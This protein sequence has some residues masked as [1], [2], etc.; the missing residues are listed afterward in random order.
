MPLDY[1]LDV[2]SAAGLSNTEHAAGFR[3]VCRET[4][5]RVMAGRPT[6]F[7]SLVGVIVLTL[8]VFGT[9][10]CTAAEPARIGI[11]STLSGPEAVLGADVRDGARLAVD[12]AIAA[13]ANVET[14]VYDDRGTVAG[15]RDAERHAMADRAIVVVG[16]V[17]TALSAEVGPQYARDGLCS[18][19]PT[20]HGDQ[21]TRNATTFRPL[22]SASEMGAALANYLRYALGGTRAVVIYRENAFGR[23]LA[24]GFERVANHGGLAVDARGYT[25]LAQAA[26]LA[27]DVARDPNHPAVII[28][29][30]DVDAVPIVTTLRRA[31]A[32]NLILGPSAIADDTF[33]RNFAG[34]PEERGGRGFFTNGIYAASP[35]ILD[36][37]NAAT[38]SFAQRFRARFLRDPS[39]YATQGYESALLAIAAA[40]TAAGD[41]KATTDRA[42]RDAVRAYLI[43]LDGPAHALPGLLGPLWFT[44]ARGRVEDVRIGRFYFDHLE[45]APLQ[46]VPVTNFDAADVG[47][48]AVVDLGDGRFARRQRVVYSGIF[49]NEIPRL[50]IAQSLFTADFY[51]WIRYA[52]GRWPGAADPADIE[53][54]DLQ[55]GVFDATK[56]SAS[57]DLP[58]GTS[59]RLWHV[60][61]DFKNAFD[62]HRFP[63]DTQTLTI[64]YF[65]ATA[66]SDRIMYAD[67]L[68]ASAQTNTGSTAHSDRTAPDALAELTQWTPLRVSRG[69]AVLVTPSALGDPR[70]VGLERQREL[71]GFQSTV[72]LRR[73][74]SA[75][76]LKNLLPL[77][78]MT[79]IMFAALYFPATLVKEKVTVAITAALSGAV[80]L[81]SINGQLGGVGYTIL[82]EYVFFVFFGLCLLSIV[83][84][85][86]AERLRASNHGTAAARADQIT[87]GV[88]AGTVIV[89]CGLAWM[90]AR[91]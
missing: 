83:S 68:R 67:D 53:F 51:L 65:N 18:I 46:L 71:S 77:G 63:L 8:F 4:P 37:A 76:L 85:L 36:S 17:L 56:P 74:T 1:A 7:A 48:G 27:H 69:R 14:A 78:L 10:V 23:P 13:G 52:Q 61:G 25:T 44:P 9:A 72:V 31:H 64:R 6:M 43:S 42:R 89:L 54:P 62:L 75:T 87:R 73:L 30:V 88:F 20:A 28:G 91:T 29:G 35:M 84:V 80:L 24:A 86:A 3:L 59:Y 45:S 39:Y 12:E 26:K 50:D 81:S 66:A 90:A 11:A 70:L 79:L 16:P 57:S 49:L 15:A 5:S 40:R 55:R 47:T 60:R 33:A 58:D 82:V 19:V 38:L 32:R 21:L 34:L 2:R 22:F 41:Q